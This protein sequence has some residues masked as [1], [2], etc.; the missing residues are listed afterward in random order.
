M[1][2]LSF[3]SGIK[4]KHALFAA[5]AFA[6]GIA[7]WQG[8]SFIDDKIEAE[9]QVLLLTQEIADQEE[10]LRILK[11]AAA[12]RE[13]AQRAADAARSELEA[14]EDALDAIRR[15]IAASPEGDDGEV[16]PVLRRVI[17]ALP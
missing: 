6:I 5:A 1:P 8:K 3:F 16:A 4:L 13:S 11:Q 7:V 9:R 14:V 12:Q 10:A 15:G 17:D 2:F